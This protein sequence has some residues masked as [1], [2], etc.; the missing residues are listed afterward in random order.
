M[1]F[2]VA[3]LSLALAFS[4]HAEALIELKP[5]PGYNYLTRHC[6]G[7]PGYRTQTYVT[8]FDETG[9]VTG[10]VYASTRCP[11]VYR[12]GPSTS[13]FSW[14]SIVWDLNGTALETLPWDGIAP[15]PGFTET[16]EAGDTIYDVL[17]PSS[18]GMLYQGMLSKP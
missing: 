7:Y 2:A 13:Y 15:D 11:S 18:Y 6:G 4:I 10:E 8:G 3:V 12:Y 5:Q 9:N 1:K 17:K 14:H 16:D